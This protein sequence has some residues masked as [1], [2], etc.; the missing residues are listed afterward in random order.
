M[1]NKNKLQ[2]LKNKRSDLIRY[3]HH[4]GYHKKRVIEIV[5][6]ISSQHKSN[7]ITYE[8]YSRKLSFSLNQRTP[9]QWL[10]YYDERIRECNKQLERVAGEIENEESR[11]RKINLLPLFVIVTMLMLFGAGLFF[12]QPAITGLIT[13][14][15]ATIE[16]N[17]SEAIISEE[18]L[19]LPENL[20]E[21]EL[22][23]EITISHQLQAIIFFLFTG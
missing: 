7:R 13:A 17:I 19:T 21:I 9:E 15:N 1:L 10:D 4:C 18:N 22:H 14:D 3:L 23:E 2:E 8:E 16:E 20:T 5:R 12:L 11:A 6:E